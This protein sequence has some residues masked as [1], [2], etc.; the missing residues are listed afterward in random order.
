MQ[1]AVELGAGADLWLR[2]LG[3]WFRSQRQQS[4]FFIVLQSKALTPQL[5]QGR[6]DPAFSTINIHHFGFG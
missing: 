3:C 5:P 2:G 1:V 6:S 4:D